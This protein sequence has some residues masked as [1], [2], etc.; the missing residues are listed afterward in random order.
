MERLESFEFVPFKAAIDNKADAVMVAHILMTNIDPENPASLSK[1][2]ISGILRK[3]LGFNGVVITDD[4]TMGAIEKNYSI[5]DAVVR[6]FQ[7]GS[8]IILVCHGYD[9]EL[10]AIK[11]LKE[12]I[13]NGKITEDR[14][15]ESIYRILMLKR[16]YLLSDK[17]TEAVNVDEINKK[18]E[19]VLGK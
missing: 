14:L 8:D 2:I 4:M 9:K 18:I 3:K 1:I 19:A 6:S 16:R 17:V 15:N 5:G 12:A 10:E 7:A 13:K 11:A